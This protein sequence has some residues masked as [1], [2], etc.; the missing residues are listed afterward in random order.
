MKRVIFFLLN[1]FLLVGVTFL[2]Q[3]KPLPV[4][5]ALPTCSSLG[6]SCGLPC[7]DYT[8]DKCSLAGSCTSGTCCKTCPPTPTNTTK[9]TNT[10]IPNNC[11]LDSTCKSHE[12][13]YYGLCDGAKTCDGNCCKPC[14]T[15]TPTKTPTPTNTPKPVNNCK[16]ASTCKAEECDALG[17]CAG[18]GTCGGWCCQACIPTATPTPTKPPCLHPNVCK[19]WPCY[20]Y[21][22][23]ANVD[24]VCINTAYYCC[25]PIPT[26]T[27]V[28]TNTPTPTPTPNCG[29]HTEPC[30]GSE[31]KCKTNTTAT[32][33][34]DLYCNGDQCVLAYGGDVLQCL[35]P[36]GP[37]P[38]PPIYET[39]YLEMCIKYITGATVYTKDT[40]A[41][42][43]W[44]FAGNCPS[45]YKCAPDGINCAEP[46]FVGQYCLQACD[47]PGCTGVRLDKLRCWTNYSA[48]ELAPNAPTSISDC[49]NITNCIEDAC[50]VRWEAC[51]G[52]VL[53][54]TCDRLYPGRGFVPH[55]DSCGGQDCGP[56]CNPTPTG[57]PGNPCVP[58]C[59]NSDNYC[60]GE[61]F[62]STN[63]CGICYGTGI[64][65]GTLSARAVMVTASDTS[66]SALTS[67]S[68]N[69]LNTVFSFTPALVPATK[70]QTSSTPV[71][72]TEVY[73]DGTT[74]YRVNATPQNALTQANV[75]AS[76]NG[77]A[78]T[79]GSARTLSKD[80]T[81]DFIVGYL[82]QA[83]WVQT[84]GGNVYATNMLRS[85][86]PSTAT[87]PYF[88]LSGAMGSVGMVSYGSNYDFSLETANLGETMVSTTNWLVQHTNASLDYYTQFASRME[89]PSSATPLT[90]LTEIDKPTCATSPCVYYADGNLTTSTINSWNIAANEQIILF[91]NGNVTINR[92]ITITYGGFFALVTHGDITI[93]STVGT[94]AGVAT[95]TLE[96]IYIATN[97]DHSAVFS[98]GP[99]VVGTRR[100]VIQGSVIADEFQLLRDLDL[101]NSTTPAEQFIFD[102]QLLFT[103]PDT[104]KEIP[105]V[106][107]EVAP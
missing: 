103:M 107:Q 91:V 66:C 76:R 25:K 37:T 26:S 31:Q 95:P 101:T 50:V 98:T 90:Q 92:P 56:P 43:G 106:W 8:P 70:T 102:P 34:D 72:W 3:S 21:Q 82:P 80:G 62:P 32:I 96:G 4:Q 74:S 78:Y 83:G 93:S 19:E 10:P 81:I 40:C 85:S 33:E 57:N 46:N 59:D 16:G 35:M 71:T 65:S 97:A 51:G 39:G 47:Y 30:C 14:P 29:D 94:G 6:G 63:D 86:I 24:A 99:S 18:L 68:T 64:C 53:Q 12:C 77:N 49:L 44:R 27:S 23:M 11:I 87:N 84:V 69:V 2:I 52:E 104:M 5:A 20:E 75:C 60:Y 67:S 48:Y 88:T 45:G 13:S 7:A 105:Y 41:A 89:V 55:Y 36:T 58:Q 17:L 42:D 38:V 79:Q 15:N 100:L 22:G 28:P 61:T 54:E 1:I 9:P 73:T